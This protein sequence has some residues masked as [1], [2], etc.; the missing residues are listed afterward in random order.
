MQISDLYEQAGIEPDYTP[1][2]TVFNQ[3]GAGI[4]V[5]FQMMENDEE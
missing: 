3:I 4:A 5:G 1:V 2:D